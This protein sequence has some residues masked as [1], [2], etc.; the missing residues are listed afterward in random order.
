MNLEDMNLNPG[1]GQD[2][3]LAS[4]L[5]AIEATTPV[6]ADCAHRPV[7]PSASSRVV[8]R[9]R[10]SMIL[11]PLALSKYSPQSWL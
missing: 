2:V 11:N 3:P 1:D 9:P 5:I 8:H 6:F 4:E 10:N 7:N